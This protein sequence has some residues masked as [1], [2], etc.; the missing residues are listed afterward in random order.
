MKII[1]VILCCLLPL[2]ANAAEQWS[3]IKTVEKIQVMNGRTFVVF[4]DSTVASQCTTAGT[5]S[6]YIASGQKGVNDVDYQALLSVFLSAFHTQTSVTVLY[7]NA[8]S[9]CWTKRVEMVS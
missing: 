3:G 1:L 9:N 4:F 8:T 7:D 2:T 5:D 6:V